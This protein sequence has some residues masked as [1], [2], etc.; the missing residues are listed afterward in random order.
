MQQI[1]TEAAAKKLLINSGYGNNPSGTIDL[2]QPMLLADSYTVT[3]TF[4]T[5]S[6]TKEAAGTQEFFLPGGMRLLGLSGDD[7][8]GVFGGSNLKPDAEIPCYSVHAAEDLSLEA[9]PGSQFT[10]VPSDVHVKTSYLTFDAHWALDKG[11]ISVHRVF[12][13]NIDRA[14]CSAA[15]RAANAKALDE[16][17]DSYNVQLSLDTAAGPV[18]AQKPWYADQI[19]R[20]PSDPKLAATLQDVLAAM[21]RNDDDKALSLLSDV[22]KQPGLP[23]SV[24]YPS[25]Y[26]RAVIYARRWRYTDALA[27]LN[28]ELAATPGDTRML[29]TRAHVY[30]MMGDWGR[31]ND[32]VNATLASEPGDTA[33]LHLRGNIAV[34]Y[35]RYQDAVDAYSQE[36]Q[37]TPYANAFFLRAV[38]YHRLGREADAKADIDKASALADAQARSDYDDIVFGRDGLPPAGPT[39]AAPSVGANASAGT[40]PPQ[41][42]GSPKSYYPALSRRL[43]EE[44]QTRVSFMI[45]TDGTVRNVRIDASSGFSALD[46]AAIASVK[47]WRYRPGTEDGK[48]VAVPKQVAVRWA[49]Q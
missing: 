24:S 7:A 1:G 15:I 37:I 17:S 20:P 3:G 19:A 32:D 38:A 9:P 27:D 22:L 2:Q 47:T 11:T 21:K 26:N 5:D 40:S 31:A 29:G 4:T 45:G 42:V 10:N 44:G 25:H 6:W 43:G 18:T 23:I 48:A 16:I 41:Q 34:E 36:L 12:A 8:M 35:G 13:S 14:L 39:D 49:L 30:F 28:A 46:A 33:A